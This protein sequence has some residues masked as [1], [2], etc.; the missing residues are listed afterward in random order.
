ML[1]GDRIVQQWNIEKARKAARLAQRINYVLQ[2]ILAT[3]CRELTGGLDAI[4]TWNK[5]AEDNRN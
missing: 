4:L 5:Y 3:E 2:Y 1:D